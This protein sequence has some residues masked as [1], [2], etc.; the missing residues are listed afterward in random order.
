M[1]MG[2]PQ[3]GHVPSWGHGPEAWGMLQRPLDWQAQ[4][5]DEVGQ[6]CLKLLGVVAV[7]EAC[8]LLVAPSGTSSDAATASRGKAEAMANTLRDPCPAIRSPPKYAL[9]MAPAEYAAK[10][11][12]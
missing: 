4:A 10:H 8:A 7:A 12:D 1:G 2:M 3:C 6:L 5:V 11:S 9:T